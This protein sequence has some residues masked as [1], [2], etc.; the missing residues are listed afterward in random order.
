MHNVWL[1]NMIRRLFATIFSLFGFAAP[2]KAA[3]TV[4]RLAELLNQ[5]ANTD[6]IDRSVAAISLLEA[7]AVPDWLPRLHEILATP[8]DPYMREGVAPAIIRL[9]GIR[10]L[11]RLLA[12]LR[13][14]FAEGHDCD[15]LQAYVCDLVESEPDESS[16]M[17]LP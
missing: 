1:K 4:P 14:G 6:D 17:L 12:A 5:L 10:A 8:G 3:D 16:Q 2:T 9:E 13:L 7:E 15:S 11:P